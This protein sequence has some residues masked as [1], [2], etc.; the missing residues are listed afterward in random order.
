MDEF[1]PKSTG[2]EAKIEKK[3]IRAEKR[4]ERDLS[5]GKKLR[6]SRPLS[7]INCMFCCIHRFG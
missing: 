7:K 3:K 6:H 5:P 2:R 1:A 4:R